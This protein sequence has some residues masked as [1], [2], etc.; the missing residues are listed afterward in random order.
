MKMILRNRD[1]MLKK[2][3]LICP[4]I[5]D[6]LEVNMEATRDCTSTWS[7]GSK[8]EVHCKGKQFVVDLE[9]RSCACYRWDIIGIPCMHAVSAIAYKKEMAES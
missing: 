3:G 4:R 1:T 5:Q 6:K 9:K 2:S 7:G 8:F